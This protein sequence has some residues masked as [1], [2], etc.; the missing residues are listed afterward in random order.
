MV[1]ADSHLIEWLLHESNITRYKISKDVNI[2]ESTLSRIASGETPMDA[3]RFGYARKLTEYARS[4]QEQQGLA[5]Y[6]KN[7]RIIEETSKEEGGKNEQ[8]TTK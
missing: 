3:M 7:Q 1:D 2:A 6:D 5:L 8:C 4:I